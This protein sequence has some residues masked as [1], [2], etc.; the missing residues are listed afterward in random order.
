[1]ATAFSLRLRHDYKAAL[2]ASVEA[3]GKGQRL[4]SALN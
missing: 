2:A 4:F 1:M 3:V